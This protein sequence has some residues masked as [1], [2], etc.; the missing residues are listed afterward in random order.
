MVD[1]RAVNLGGWL[2]LEKWMTP[3]LF[4][5]TD[6]PDEYNLLLQ[7][8]DKRFDIMKEHRDTYMKEEDFKWISDYGIDTVRIPVGHWLFEAQSPYIEAQSYLDLAFYWA[9]KYNLQ[10]MLDVHAAPGC[11]NGFDNGG[12][13]GICLWHTKQEYIDQTLDFIKKL[14][15]VYKDNPMFRGIELLNEPRWD[16]PM[17]IIQQFY[18]DGYQIVRDICGKEKY[19][20]FHDAF[21]IEQ[22]ETFSTVNSFDNVYL[23]TH[24]YQVFSDQDKARS[25]SEVIEKVSI[26]RT[27]ELKEVMKYVKVIVGEWSLGIPHK[28]LDEAKTAF[29][30]DALYRAVGNSLLISFEQSNGWVFWNYKLNKDSFAYNT[31]WS[32]RRCVELGWLPP[33]IEEEE[34]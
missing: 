28:A 29:R 26:K 17:D 33:M 5:G 18:L 30:K 24:M 9:N 15:E 20:V 7:L 10:V 13:S 25:M 2:V 32:F 23:D 21:R 19:V 6:A 8:G 31:G 27:N 16:V 4:D 34:V 1:M 14:C 12:L 3:S 22:W 11:Q